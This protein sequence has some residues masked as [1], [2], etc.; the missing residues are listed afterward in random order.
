MHLTVDFSALH[1]AVQQMGAQAVDPE[2]HLG[3][4]RENGI[5]LFFLISALLKNCFSFLPS[6]FR[7]AHT[8]GGML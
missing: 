8:S 2:F 7:N 3:R 4:E 5:F 1:A 6:H